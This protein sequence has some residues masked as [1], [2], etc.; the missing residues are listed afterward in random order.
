MDVRVPNS[1][2]LS[3]WGT[4]GFS[5][6]TNLRGDILVVLNLCVPNL[7]YKYYI[8]FNINVLETENGKGV[9]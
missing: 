5:K 8:K 4:T 6:R 9:L 2:L 1:E 7:Y 3:G